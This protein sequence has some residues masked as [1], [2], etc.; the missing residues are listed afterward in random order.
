[1]YVSYTQQWLSLKQIMWKSAVIQVNVGV[2][3]S[4]IQA[5]SSAVRCRISLTFQ[6]AHNDENHDRHSLA[7]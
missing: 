3:P 2:L 4:L 6:N 1:M 5:M 7:V